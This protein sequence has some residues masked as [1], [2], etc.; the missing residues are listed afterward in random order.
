MSIDINPNFPEQV[1]I[2]KEQAIFNFFNLNTIWWIKNNQ[3]YRELI[4]RK[5]NINFP[6]SRFISRALKIQQKRGPSFTARFLNSDKAKNKKHFFIGLDQKDAA[7]LSI[8]CGL[9][10]SNIKAYNPPHIKETEFSVDERDKIIKKIKQSKS[11]FVWVCVGSPKQEIL[12]NQLF[13]KHKGIYFNV[14]AATDF[15]LKKKKEAPEVFRKVGLE[16][17][18]RLV[19]DFKTTR[20]KAWRSF[21]ALKYINQ[22]NLK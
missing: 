1:L 15:L 20:K 13:K 8:I 4:F 7:N 6:D 17:F 21:V 10:I 3:P 22:L 12:A 11:D 19:T 2:K 18:Y 9:E 14:G 5:E 16:W